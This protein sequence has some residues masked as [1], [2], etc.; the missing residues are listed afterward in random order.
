MRHAISAS[1][2]IPALLACGAQEPPAPDAGSAPLA[3]A[4]NVDGA[5]IAAAPGGEVRGSLLD[6]LGAAGSTVG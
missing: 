1:L 6:V 4:G 3:Q 2:L 5:R